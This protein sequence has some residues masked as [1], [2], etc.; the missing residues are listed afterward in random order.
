MKVP[1]LDLKAQYHPLR[2][3]IRAAM[4]RVCDAQHFIL[5]PEV[6]GLEAELAAFCGAKH[7]VGVSSGTD[8]L[9]LALMAL[10]VGPGDEVITTSYSFFATAGTVA[11][12]GATP[13]FVDIEAD[14]FNIAAARVE[15]KITPK[16]KAILPVHLYGRC[17]ELDPILAAAS[18]HGIPVIEDAAQAIGA[19]DARKR[20]AGTVGTMGCFSFFPTKNLGAF[21]DGG[22]VTTN[23]AA[24]AEQLR[25]LRVHGS[26]PKYYHKVVGG[27]FR[28]DALQ[29]AV[30]RVKLPHLDSWS[31]AR[32]RNAD[33]YRAHFEKAGLGATLT[34]P[35]DVPGHIYNQ[36]VIRTPKR[37]ALQKHLTEMGVGTEIY[38]PVPLHL[39]ECFAPLGY[40]KGDLPVSE[41]V[42]ADCLALPI[43]PE[44]SGAQ[45]AY[46]V[47]QIAV[48]CRR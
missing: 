7:V 38:Y 37:D 46:V 12:L 43:Y 41:A 45:Q 25:I 14:S 13:V 29:A 39:Q 19:T 27:N 16:T 21:G 35:K 31:A 32:R 40:K 36:F 20:Q 26:K 33:R 2:E 6:E 42:A 10:E 28:L 23:D 18:K 22:L 44:L 47:E 15:S 8:A 11:R 48:F 1:L 24:L 3:Q 17:A 34:L 5:G 9:L 4:D 30:L